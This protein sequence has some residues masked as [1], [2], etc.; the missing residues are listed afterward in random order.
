MQI[1]YGNKQGKP[2]TFRSGIIK[3]DLDNPKEYM[4]VYECNV[5]VKMDQFIQDI[6]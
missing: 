2:R 3:C 5:Y 6:F 1:S 4:Y